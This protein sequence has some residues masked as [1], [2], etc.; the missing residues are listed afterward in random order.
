MKNK[1]ISIICAALIAA[2]AALSAQRISVSLPHYAGKQY[3]FS[4]CEGTRQDTI[5]KGTLNGQGKATL[6]IPD[7][8]RQY[9]GMGYF[10]LPESGGGG[11]DLIVAG[12]ESA[13]VTCSEQQ[14]TIDN[15]RILLSPENAFLVS[16]FKRGN[17]LMQQ[18]RL[19]DAVLQ[20][21]DVRTT[22]GREA[23]KEQRRLLAEQLSYDSLL[24]RSK[25]YAPRF[26]K[27]S[28]YLDDV[29]NAYLKKPEELQ[30]I[31]SYGVEKLDMEALYSSGLWYPVIDY[32]VAMYRDFIKEDTALQADVASILKRIRPQ[33]ILEAFAG[34][35]LT[36]CEQNN[37]NNTAAVILDY[38]AESGRMENSANVR[39]KDLLVARKIRPG[40]KAPAL[41][42]MADTAFHAAT[43]L[44]VFYETGCEHC[45]KEVQQLIQQYGTLT[46]KGIDVI[47]VSSDMDE[48][49]FNF[50]ATSFPWKNKLCDLKG[51]EGV[52]FK[53]YGVLGTPT[54]FVI[55]SNGI[56]RGKYAH[57][58]DAVPQNLR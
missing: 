47:S 26:L 23:Q 32:W 7:A 2:P 4:L 29:A 50:G 8:R 36:I 43:T 56:I 38:L 27:L 3:I 44:L 17:R 12:G 28:R 42:G 51:S 55:D 24:N 16:Q 22:F 20:T 5:L 19:L 11:L 25:L 48:K 49:V 58:A 15:V 54:I 52:N 53:N 37:W 35:M 34:D 9:R 14:L 31:R 45:E 41:A 30:K 13:L 40:A 6:V 33:A 1:S 21:Y 57:L 10:R 18:T 46:E 39:L